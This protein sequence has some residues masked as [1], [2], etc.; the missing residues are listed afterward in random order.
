MTEQTQTAPDAPAAADAE[1]VLAEVYGMAGSALRLPSEFDH[2][3]RIDT[4]HGRRLTLKF[5]DDRLTRPDVLSFQTGAL[6]HVGRVAPD[7]PVPKLLPSRDGATIV[8]HEAFG[9]RFSLR[10]LTWLPG[11]PLHETADAAAR[12]ATLGRLLGRL[13]LALEGYRPTVPDFDLLWDLTRAHRVAGWAAGIE[14]D[15]LRART[16]E[17]F[18]AHA[19]L[20]PQLSRLPRQV[21]HNDLNPHNVIAVPASDDGI[22]GIIDFGDV[23]AAPRINDLAIALS[24]QIG[25]PDGPALAAAMVRGY[26]A[27]VA[28]APGE[29]EAILPLVRTRLAM[30]MAITTH[31][32][33]Q[34]PDQ[35]GYILRNRPAAMA[36]LDRLAALSAADW[37]RILEGT[38]P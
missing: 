18:A 24:Y 31:R 7:L 25:R 29:G 34:H 6:D 9:R 20:A 37:A 3:F 1:A 30:T 4:G 23:V 8:P 36:G 38:A 35:A 11:T 22:A 2:T 17:A 16:Q 33:R 21:I 26:R 13:D 27:S 14:D 5:S 10:L 15:R 32:A 19:A 28:L 12:M